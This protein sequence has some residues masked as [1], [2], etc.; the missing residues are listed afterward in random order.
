VGCGKPG[1]NPSPSSP[2]LFT[3]TGGKN[4]TG[5]GPYAGE[6]TWSTTALTPQNT[7]VDV[8]YTVPS[9]HGAWF[10]S[11]GGIRVQNEALHDHGRALRP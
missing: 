10:I 3:A 1:A 2:W 4:G 7:G 11:A 9:G 5:S 6:Q 8:H